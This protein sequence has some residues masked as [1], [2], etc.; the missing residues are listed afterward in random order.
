MEHSENISDCITQIKLS[1]AHFETIKTY[2]NIS[3]T[4]IP[5]LK[6]FEI[7]VDLSH[8]SWVVYEKTGAKPLMWTEP[9]Q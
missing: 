8:G 3:E 1:D 6:L 7:P 9:I 4:Q 5:T 2:A